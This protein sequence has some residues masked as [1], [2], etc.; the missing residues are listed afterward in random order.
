MEF[1][2]IFIILLVA[3]LI[4]CAYNKG[5]SRGIEIGREQM[6]IEDLK[7]IDRHRHIDIAYQKAIE[8]NN[9][10]LLENI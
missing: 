4:F 6:L 9:L 8:H 5:K 10:L 2:L 1:L 7:R 3:L